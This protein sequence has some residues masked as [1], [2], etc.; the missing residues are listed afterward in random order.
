ME[1]H[2][3]Y[4]RPVAETKPGLPQDGAF[5]GL[6]VHTMDQIIS[7]FGRP[8]HVAYDIRSLRNKANPTTPLKRSCFMAI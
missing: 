5:Y 7:L 4:Y 2:F 8:D 3:D 1:S 6:G